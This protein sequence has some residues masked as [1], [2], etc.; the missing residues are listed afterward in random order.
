MEKGHPQEDLAPPYPGPPMNYG[1]AVQQP[2][3]YPQPGF[4]PAGP[5][6]VYQGGMCSAPGC[7]CHSDSH[8]GNTSTARCPGTNRVPPLPADGPHQDRALTRPANLG[9]LWWPHPLW[10]LSLL[11]YPVLC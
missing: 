4:S 11:L 3:M 7:T 10:V 5:P 9:H 8:D 2:G 1:G 6:P